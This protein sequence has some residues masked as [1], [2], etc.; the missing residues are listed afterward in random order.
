MVIAIDSRPMYLK[1]VFISFYKSFSDDFLS[2]SD[3]WVKPKRWEKIDRASYPYNKVPIENY[4]ATIVS[5]NE[6]G[7]SHLLN[8]IEKAISRE[9]IEGSNFLQIKEGYL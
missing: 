6:S 4:I 5:A 8:V 9:K 7:N 2:K 3:G 1:A